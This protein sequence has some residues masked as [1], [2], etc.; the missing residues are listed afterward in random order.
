MHCTAARTRAVLALGLELPGVLH[1]ARRLLAPDPAGLAAA[2]RPSLL[3]L[4]FSRLLPALGPA[5][6]P[7]VLTSSLIHT[8]YVSLPQSS[9]D[10][11]TLKFA[12]I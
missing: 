3:L 12:G 11:S 1:R 10:V 7:R 5:H 4:L 2:A 9:A 6:H 8:Q